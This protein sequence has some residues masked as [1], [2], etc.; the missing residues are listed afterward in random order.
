MTRTASLSQSVEIS[1]TTRRWPGAFALEPQFLARAAEECGEAGFDCLAE[2]FFVHVA[3][4]EDASRGV[5]LNDRR[6]EAVE[7]PEIQIHI[8]KR[9]ARDLFGAAGLFAQVQT[10]R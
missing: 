6:D 8:D 4:H 1:L 9:K 7:F 5:V 10:I 2:R 3:D